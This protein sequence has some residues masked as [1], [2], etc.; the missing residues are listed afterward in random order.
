MDGTLRRGLARARAMWREIRAW[1]R[2][3]FT[4]GG[5]VFTIGALA[6]GLAA[7]NTGNNLLF[8]LLGAMLG[9]IAISGWLSE[10]VIRDIEVTRRV[11][12]G[13]TVGHDVRIAYEVRN[14]R[15]HL[16]SLALE[17]GEEGLPERAFLPRVP[18][19]GEADAR[20]VNVF[21]RRGIYPLRSVTLA[22]AFPFGLFLKERD[23]SLPGELVIWPRHDLPVRPPRPAG[24]RALRIGA[25]PVGAAGAR[26]EYRGLRG[27]RPG[28]DPRDIHWRTSARLDTPVVREY[29]RD[30]AET[31][32]ICLDVGGEPGEAA[33]GV[34]EV[35]ASLAAG[36]ASEGKRFGIVGGG[37]RLEPGTG[38]GQLEAALDLLA[39]VDFRPDAPPPVPPAEPA[40]CVLV[41]LTARASGAFGDAYLGA[42]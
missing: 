8:L 13:A 38:S 36:A 6:V 26:G 1:R 9:F 29:E 3:S 31:M 14:R 32:W 30:G 25:A 20:S 40:R 19:Q 39:R 18:A 15:K 4:R 10:L 41:A 24:A 2:I 27:Y 5:A 7:M 33:E 28:D 22:T 17:L 12:R 23:L 37:H 42:E 11:P 35:A 21:V 16:P 34:V